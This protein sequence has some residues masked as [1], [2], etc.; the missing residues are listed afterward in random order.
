[1]VFLKCSSSSSILRHSDSAAETEVLIYE[2]LNGTLGVRL[3][4]LMPWIEYLR[5]V[6]A[7]EI[8]D[9]EIPTLIH[10]GFPG[11]VV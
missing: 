5:P 1:M 7:F 6:I 10:P 8:S 3:H 11:K 2:K 4:G 9:L